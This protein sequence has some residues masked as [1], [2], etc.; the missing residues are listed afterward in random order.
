MVNNRWHN[1][2]RIVLYF[3]H[4][5]DNNYYDIVLGQNLVSLVILGGSR[6]PHPQKPQL[7]VTGMNNKINLILA[8]THIKKISNVS[9]M[10]ILMVISHAWSVITINCRFNWFKTMPEVCYI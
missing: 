10:K 5:H 2:I 1:N 3:S 6:K 8:T 9:F 7:Q 4:V